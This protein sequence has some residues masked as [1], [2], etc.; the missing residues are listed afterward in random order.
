MSRF[1]PVTSMVQNNLP[2]PIGVDQVIRKNRQTEF[3]NELAR[4]AAQT[5]QVNAS[6]FQRQNDLQAERQQMQIDGAKREEY[7]QTGIS[8]L[9]WLDQNQGRPEYGQMLEQLAADPESQQAAGALGI[10]LAKLGDPAYRAVAN[11]KLRVPV[12]EKVVPFEDTPE[13]KAILLRGKVDAEA[14][15]RRYRREMEIARLRQQ[16]GPNALPNEATTSGAPKLPIG[17]LKMVDEATQAINTSQETL[18]LVSDAKALV[19]TNRVNLGAV[20]NLEAQGRNALGIS[21]PNSRAF[22]SLQQTLEKLRNNY[23]LLAKGVQTEGDAQRAWDSE[24]GKNAQR[25][26]KLAS[27][28][29]EKAQRLTQLAIERQQRRIAGVYAN[30]G[31]SAPQPAGGE[32]YLD[33][34]TPTLPSDVDAI[35]KKYGS[36]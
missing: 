34:T 22:A 7:R 15:A 17:A 20:A 11:A 16:P 28:Q 8:L 26:N 19:D 21:D 30:Y 27:Q 3:A 1:T 4:M 33:Q 6:Q 2:D 32:G 29:L 18:A 5:D 35:L 10:D 14:D 9:G 31:A 24:I 25:D 12:P 13:A 23:L 36:K